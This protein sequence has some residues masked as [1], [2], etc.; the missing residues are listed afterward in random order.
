M[1]LPRGVEIRQYLIKQLDEIIKSGA[2]NVLVTNPDGFVFLSHG[3]IDPVDLSIAAS[4]ASAFQNTIR[5][6]NSDFYYKLGLL[7]KK[8]IKI[9]EVSLFQYILSYGDKTYVSI[10]IEGYSI[11]SVVPDPTKIQEISDL[12]LKTII[13]V[14][15]VFREL[16]KR[17]TIES[18]EIPVGITSIPTTT[19]EEVPVEEQIN[20]SLFIDPKIGYQHIR[21]VTLTALKV[22]EEKG[23]WLSA[24]KA[25][26]VISLY[27]KTLLKKNPQYTENNVIMTINRWVEKTVQ[28]IQTLLR[29]YGNSSIDDKRKQILKQGLNQLLNYL[30]REIYK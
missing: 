4:L 29:T 19:L 22:L 18:P 21:Q 24:L 27:I 15:N 1:A 10:F 28:R 12:L 11:I 17:I 2:K 5:Y 7:L 25:F 20:E 9:N 23:D 6:L 3:D 26:Q 8:A 14:M 30:R 16:R 13:Q